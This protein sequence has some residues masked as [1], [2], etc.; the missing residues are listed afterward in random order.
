MAI[1][2]ITAPTLGVVFKGQMSDAKS[3][4][5]GMA[6]RAG[7]EAVDLALAGITGPRDAFEAAG[8]FDTMTG[9][10]FIAPDHNAPF[11]TGADVSLKAYPTVF[12][13]HTAIA[14]AIELATRLDGRLGDISA[15]RVQVPEKVAAM[16]AAPQ[17]WEVSTREAAQFSLPLAVA[18]SLANGACGLG[19]LS[20]DHLAAPEVKALLAVM[21]VGVEPKWQGYEG[22]RVEVTLGDGTTETSET[23]A[24]PGHPNNPMTSEQVLAKFM[25][26]AAETLGAERATKVSAEVAALERAPNIA[27]LLGASRS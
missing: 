8:G 17:R 26:L 13:T 11:L 7:W 15:V 24:A 1:G 10:P 2:A 22:G 3:L 14:S 23:T 20:P 27:A 19:E 16:A 4:V 5:N 21:D 9:G 12:M 18:T 25:S 6:A